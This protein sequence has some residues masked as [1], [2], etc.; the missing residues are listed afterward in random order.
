MDKGRYRVAV[1]TLAKGDDQLRRALAQARR[2]SQVGGHTFAV[3]VTPE[4]VADFARTL[5]DDPCK[6]AKFGAEMVPLLGQVLTKIPIIMK[7]A[8]VITTGRRDARPSDV[9][10]A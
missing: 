10:V 8:L 6:V 1:A 3:P 9:E 2:P 7:G 5:A 4:Q